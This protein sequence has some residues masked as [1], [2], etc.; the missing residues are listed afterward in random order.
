ML[1][2][3]AAPLSLKAIE[4]ATQDDIVLIAGKGHE[5][6]QIFAHKTI[7]FDDAKMATQTCQQIAQLR[8]P[9][10]MPT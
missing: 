7:E 2:W 9:Q 3:T 6:Y 10:E 8:K 4:M 5:T 1:N